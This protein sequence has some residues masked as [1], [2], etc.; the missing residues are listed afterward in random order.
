M[1]RGGPTALGLLQRRLP[2][3]L[4]MRWAASLRHTRRA[5]SIKTRALAQ[6]RADGR[7]QGFQGFLGLEALQRPTA[8]RVL[9][10]S[11][12]RPQRVLSASSACPQPVLSL[13]SACPQHVLM[14]G[15][16][17]SYVFGP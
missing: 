13:S 14:E 9:S 7:C 2:R 10:V 4:W 5:T 8:V 6:A 17:G 15:V 12:A 11:S 3:T 16:R 1:S